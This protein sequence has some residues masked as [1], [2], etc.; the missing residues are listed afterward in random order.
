MKISYVTTYNAKDIHQWSGLGYYLAQSLENQGT[1]ID[2]IGNLNFKN[3][4][5]FKAKQFWYQRFGKRYQRYRESFVIKDYAKQVLKKLPA[6]ADIVFAPGSLPVTYLD[7]KK[8]IVVYND[9]TFAGMINYYDAFS[10]LCAETIKKGNELEQ[11]ALDNCTL[12]IYSSDWA[13]ESAIKN[14]NVSPSKIKVVPM[15]ANIACN[16]SIADIKEILKNKSKDV[17]HLLFLGVDWVRKGGDLVLETAR[18]LNERGIKTEL[19]IAGIAD[20]PVKNL[21][22]FVKSYGFISKSTPEGQKKLSALI[23]QS[24]FLVVPSQAEA[25][26]L[27]FCEAN[28]FGLP[29]IATKTGGIPTI[30]K[31]DVNGF[32]FD[33][34][35]KA[36]EYADYIQ[37]KL[38]NYQTYEALAL[39]SFNEYQQRLNW[40]VA[41]KQIV[42]LLKEL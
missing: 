25:Y 38:T 21:P 31:D 37:S 15:G 22:S 41:G 4:L 40:E 33:L 30:I 14:Y 39:S 6:S 11:Q 19:H 13:A 23:A 17:C 1:E 2:Y 7:T 35:A 20:L 26:G 12:A 34:N 24:H 36:P 9:A 8:P 32:T 3:E 28:S 29:A 5:F 18:L 16:R 27:V 42:E 10:N